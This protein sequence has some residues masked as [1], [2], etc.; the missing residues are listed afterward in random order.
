MN[1]NIVNISLGENCLMAALLLKY[2]IKQESY[3]F[4]SVR[5]NIEYNLKI[6]KDNFEDLLKSDLLVKKT[7]FGHQKVVKN[8]KY[9]KVQNDIYTS[10]V[11]DSFE[12]THHNVLDNNKD[13]ASY[14]RKIERTKIALESNDIIFWYHYR[15]STNN[16]LEILIKQFEDFIKYLS[17]KYNKKYQVCIF[18]QIVSDDIHFINEQYNNNI[19]IVKCYEKNVWCGNNVGGNVNELKIGGHTFTKV[20]DKIFKEYNLYNKLLK[21]FDK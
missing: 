11:I 8:K 1:N 7:V 15:Y 17:K 4:G 6:I 2:G 16:N 18:T 5:T 3:A 12:F 21:N 10:S 19:N 20:F 14:N 13:I 9:S